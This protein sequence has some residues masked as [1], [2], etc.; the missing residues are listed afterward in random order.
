MIGVNNNLLRRRELFTFG[1]HPWA[2]NS[3][4]QILQKIDQEGQRLPK[5][6]ACPLDVYQLVMHMAWSHR[7][8]DRP[9]FAALVKYFQGVRKYFRLFSFQFFLL[10]YAKMNI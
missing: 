10:F 6:A 8:Q 2:G 7:E 3:G 5:P 4:A 1:E 9:T